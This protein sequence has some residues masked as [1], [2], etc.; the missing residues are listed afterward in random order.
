MC[1]VMCFKP[2]TA[3]L[4]T[5]CRALI[6]GWIIRAQEYKW[7]KRYIDYS[8]F[9]FETINNTKKLPTPEAGHWRQSFLVCSTPS[10]TVLFSR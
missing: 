4:D 9:L 2:R 6:N 3:T 8:S 5:R 1:S 7:R 10:E